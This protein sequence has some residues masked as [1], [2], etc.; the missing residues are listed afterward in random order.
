MIPVVSKKCRECNHYRAFRRGLKVPICK[1][2]PDGI[3]FEISRGW[4]D[5]T[6]PYPGDR[7][8]QFEPADKLPQWEEE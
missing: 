8:I 2:F 4:N 5:H 3:P 7:G 1:A 6:E